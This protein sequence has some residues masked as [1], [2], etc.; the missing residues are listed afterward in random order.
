MNKHP[1]L[2]DLIKRY[3]G[4]PSRPWQATWVEPKPFPKENNTKVIHL[5]E[6]LPPK[7]NQATPK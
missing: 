3:F 1:I 7:N 4:L 6:S 2:Y 5:P